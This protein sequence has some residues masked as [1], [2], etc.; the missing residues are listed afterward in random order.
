VQRRFT[1]D[2]VLVAL[3]VTNV[4]WGTNVS[5][6]K[7]A[8]G[9]WN[10][11]AYS[12]CRFIVGTAVF[13]LWVFFREGSL[14]VARDDLPLLALCGAIGIFGNQIG[15]MYA[16]KYA[17]ATTVS[18]LMITSPMFAALTAIALRQ[19]M[20]GWRHWTGIGIAG[21]GLVLVLRGSGATLGLAS[22]KG[23]L[24]ALLMAG[25]WGVYSVLVRP[26]M[27]RYSASLISVMVL[28]VGTPLLIPFAGGQL[29]SQDFGAISAGGWSALVFSL[30]FSLV[31]TN[32]LWFGAIHKGGASRATAL[33]PLQPVVGALVAGVFL[34]ER[35]AMVELVG[36]VIVVAGI[37]ITRRDAH[38][39]DVATSD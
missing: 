34:G 36:G 16:V 39:E 30:F 25:S 13:A 20:V 15:F 21:L 4:F 29:T 38:V 24:F 28:M 35:I 37:I 11:L 1:V 27:A 22:L 17:P 9:E 2:R 32:I 8:I 23:D 5:V 10:P 19:E 31:F 6:V 26:L 7:W 14:R 3:I 18:L 33:L 12:V